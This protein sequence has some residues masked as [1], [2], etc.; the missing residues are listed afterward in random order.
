MVI[1]GE[2]DVIANFWRT[3]VGTVILA[4]LIGIFLAAQA[5]T[6]SVIESRSPQPG[7]AATVLPDPAPVTEPDC[8][9][10]TEDAV[11]AAVHD[12]ACRKDYAALRRPMSAEFSFNGYLYPAEEL[13]ARWHA[14]DPE[15]MNLDVLARTLESPVRVDQGGQTFCSTSG[16][17]AVFSR[18]TTTQ[19]PEWSMFI[20]PSSL[21]DTGLCPNS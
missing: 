11:V 8:Q 5:I 18:G 12:A 16:A 15:S 19:P 4:G 17:V 20:L 1:R 13:I 6:K 3:I 2:G 10:I 21:D 14:E 7:T 9:L